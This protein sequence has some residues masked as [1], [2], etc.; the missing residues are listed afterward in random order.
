MTKDT[1]LPPYLPFPRF[2]LEADLALTTKLVYMVLLDRAR[3]SQAN[4]W[5]DSSSQIYI[6]FPIVEI[7]NTIDRSPMTVKNSLNELESAGLIER[8]RRGQS[9]PNR[10]YIKIPDGQDIVRLTDKKLSVRRKEN[11]PSDGHKTIPLMDRKLS[12]NNL[13]SKL[14]E[15]PEGSE[16][17]CAHARGRYQNIFLSDTEI[18]EL[19]AELPDL[20][21]QYVEKL[22]EYMASTGKTYQNHAATIRR[23]AAED[24][25]KGKSIPN[26]TYEE[27]E[28]L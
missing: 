12:T 7:A 9:L 19:Q 24:R 2:L 11:C 26:Y 10:I 14:R 13:T 22:S 27:G 23:W 25:R 18:A 17:A 1:K 20:W 28:S 6:V 16:S 21:E 5:A 3:L 4:G 15:S 8:K